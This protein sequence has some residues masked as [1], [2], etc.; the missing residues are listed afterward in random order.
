MQYLN[1]FFD[2]RC[3]MDVLKATGPVKNLPKEIT[4]S[5]GILKILKSIILKTDRKFNMID[6]CA[7]NS[8]TSVLAAH[9][10]PNLKCIAMDKKERLKAQFN[11]VRNFSFVMCDIFKFPLSVSKS[12]IIISV[13]PCKR[14]AVECINVFNNSDACH[15]IIMPCCGGQVT[16]QR[17]QFLK[18]KLGAYFAWTYALSDMCVGKVS[19]RQDNNILSP[20]NL[21]IHARKK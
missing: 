10:Y 15:L 8:L 13:H 6:L 12:T 16:D 5:M 1:S 4:E 17:H 19:I 7:G 20:K 21:I 11:L 2:L 18:S 3:S 9:M 14:L